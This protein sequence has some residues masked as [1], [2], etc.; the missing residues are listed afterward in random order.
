MTHAQ[1][2]LTPA[3]HELTPSQPKVTPAQPDLTPS[4]PEVTHAQ[5]DLTPS[6]SD[7]TPTTQ[8]LISSTETMRMYY[9]I[10]PD[11]LTALLNDEDILDIEPLSVNTSPAK[12]PVNVNPIN[13]DTTTVRIKPIVITFIAAKQKVPKYVL[14]TFIGPRPKLPKSTVK[15]MPTDTNKKKGQASTY[16]SSMSDSVSYQLIPTE[17]VWCFMLTNLVTL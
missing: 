1:P 17:L 2:D 15:P 13:F 12:P 10:D 5:P 8:F 7:M 11:E 4:Q 14:R 3:Q 6:R 16:K 9:G